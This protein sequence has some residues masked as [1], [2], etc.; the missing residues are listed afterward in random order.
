MEPLP[1]GPLRSAVE[2]LAKEVEFPLTALYQVDG[3]K[4]SDHS[5]AYMYGFF[6]NKRIV[7]YDTLL[8]QC[9]NNE[10]TSILGHELGHWKYSHTVKMLGL[11][12][13]RLFVMFYFFS[14]IIKTKAVY[15]AFGF[16]DQMPVL[17]GFIIFGLIWTP[18][19]FFLTFF[20][21]Y[22]SRKFEYEADLFAL[23]LKRAEGLKSGLINIHKENKTGLNFDEWYVSFCFSL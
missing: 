14:L 19:E 7:L 10:I 1:E 6:K 8:K 16:Y 20:Q 22:L 5:N 9:S 12:Q 3:S 11:H 17:I 4:R 21:N 13:I 18:I 15:E 2:E 23:E